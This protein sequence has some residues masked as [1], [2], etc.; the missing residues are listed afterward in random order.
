MFRPRAKEVEKMKYLVRLAWRAEFVF[1]D[2][3]TAMNFAATAM[4]HKIPDEDHDLEPVTITIIAGSNE[5]VD[6]D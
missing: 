1:D 5:E 3:D 6:N 2:P 4:A